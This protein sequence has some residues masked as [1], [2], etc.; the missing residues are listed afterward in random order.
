MK[1]LLPF[2]LVL[3]AGC[4][5][6]SGPMK[7]HWQVGRYW[8]WEAESVKEIYVRDSDGAALVT[9]T[10]ANPSPTETWSVCSG[11]TGNCYGEFVTRKDAEKRA[12]DVAREIYEHR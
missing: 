8:T 11:T 5:P 2:A 1:H 4:Q 9:V 12:L 7:A 6:Y 10:Y 3:L